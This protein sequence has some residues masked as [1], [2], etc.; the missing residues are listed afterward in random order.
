VAPAAGCSGCIAPAA[1]HLH[2]MPERHRARLSATPSAA[3]SCATET[4]VFSR[5]SSSGGIRAIS[6]SS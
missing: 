4:S 5:S 6:D 3:T 1:Q 2:G